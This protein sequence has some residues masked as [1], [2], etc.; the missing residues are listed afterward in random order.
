MHRKRRWSGD[1]FVALVDR[2][3]T[4]GPARLAIEFGRSHASVDSQAARFRLR[5]STRRSRQGRTRSLKTEP[6]P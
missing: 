2:Y 5:S 6:N 4:E 3:P 1:E